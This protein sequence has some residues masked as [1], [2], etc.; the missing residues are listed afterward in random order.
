MKILTPT[1]AA[2]GIV[3]AVG[4]TVSAPASAAECIAPS[5]PGGGW[6]FT[7]RTIGRI[8]SELDLVEGNVQV[9]NMPGG[10]GAVTYA[11]VVN[12][13]PDDPEL[14]VATS[15]V[16]ITQIAQ[17][18]YPAPVDAVRYLAMLGADV[19]VIA[20]DDDSP[21]ESL[22]QL[23]E[24]M[25]NEPGSIVTAGSSGAGGWDHIRLLMVAREGGLDDLNAMRWVQFDGGTD[26]VTQMMGGQIDV[27]STDM[28]EIAGFVES[29]DIRIL[30][31]LSDEPI[32]A[33]PD[34][35]TAKSQGIDVTGYNWRGLYTGGEVSDEEYDEW[36]SDL[37]TLYNSEEW[38][39]AAVESGLIPIWRGGEEFSDFVV[40][41]AAVMEEISRDIGVI[42]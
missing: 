15:T 25:A 4:M 26:A 22:D 33:F 29:G 34:I 27:V 11:M 19:G 35:P 9:T 28:G 40:S 18:R 6:D 39:T 12:E 42:E 5:N 24:I 16:G 36:V 1:S 10:V 30:A 21:I 31:A 14:I 37:E 13:R 8:L 17:G 23:T 3:M 2:F 20:V 7:C 38:Q 41:E 32:P